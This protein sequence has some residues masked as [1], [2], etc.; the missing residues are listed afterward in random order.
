MATTWH[1]NPLSACRPGTHVPGGS[2]VLHK[3]FKV[4]Q[5]GRC[6]AAG[7]NLDLQLDRTFFIARANVAGRIAVTVAKNRHVKVGTIAVHIIGFEETLAPSSTRKI[8]LQHTLHVQDAGEHAVAPTDAVVPGPPD[9]HGM[10]LARK[11]RH[12]VPFSIP[13]EG[14][15]KT[16]GLVETH[17]A[18]DAPRSAGGAGPL[19]SS[20]AEK[21]IGG[22]RYVVCCTLEL[23]HISQT[24]PLPP[25]TTVTR[26]TVLESLPTPRAETFVFCFPQAVSVGSPL[27]AETT[28]V[29]AGRTWFGK[30]GEVRLRATAQVPGGDLTWVAG[31]PGLVSIEVENGSRRSVDTLTLCLIR[32]VKTFA[33][34]STSATAPATSHVP[35]SSSTTLHDTSTLLLPLTFSRNVVAKRV[36][37]R[38]DPSGTNSVAEALAAADDALAPGPLA[39]WRGVVKGEKRA[40]LV[41]ID[42]PI[43][44]RSIRFATL[45]DV[46][47]VIQISV[48]PRRSRPIQ[49]EIPVTILHPASLYVNLPSINAA[50]PFLPRHVSK[51]QL[52]EA[53]SAEAQ[54][55]PL[56]ANVAADTVA[57]AAERN[58]S[59]SA[60][61][62]RD[63]KSSASSTNITTTSDGDAAAAADDHAAATTAM[64]PSAPAI[65]TLASLHTV[66]VT[67]TATPA[68]VSSFSAAASVPPLRRGTAP[69]RHPTVSM[70]TAGM[71]AAVPPEN[72]P[73]PAA[74]RAA[75]TSSTGSVPLAPGGQQQQQQ[76]QQQKHAEAL[77]PHENDG[78]SYFPEDDTAQYVKPADDAT[79]RDGFGS[80]ET[81]RQGDEDI[82]ATID[83][84]FEGFPECEVR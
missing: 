62:V 39:K 78:N 30:S 17:A 7:I 11:G 1:A 72:P 60:S 55:I 81:M 66:S 47:Y 49:V 52:H 12:V 68:P 56:S 63:D 80:S 9:E 64:A 8:F 36:W 22:I 73:S 46:S 25:L 84:M 18:G 3:E 82:A 24:T 65:K 13:L 79:A 70:N 15:V 76:Q 10:W 19:P 54:Y 50:A 69:R 75:S 21:K 43:S 51:T 71:A 4:P 53:V 29:V 42:V 14:I 23:K 61:S 41:H 31:A 83:R 16:A 40:L 26:F 38:H 6:A 67:S 34:S 58:A 37:R 45:L 27:H 77:Y 44:A 33:Q 5:T 74:T 35:A 48:R 59:T 57:A 2:A 20:F 28:G 32:R